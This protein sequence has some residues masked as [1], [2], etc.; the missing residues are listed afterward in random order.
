VVATTSLLFSANIWLIQLIIDAFSLGIEVGKVTGSLIESTFLK[1][2]L[3]IVIFGAVGILG[4]GPISFSLLSSEKDKA[5]IL[6]EI[7]LKIKEV[8]TLLG[9][10]FT[11]Q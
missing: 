3:S 4:F 11:M 2:S 9:K 5:K 1:K 6:K 10:C 8:E 7:F